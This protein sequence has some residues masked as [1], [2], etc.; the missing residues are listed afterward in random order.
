MLLKKGFERVT[1][2]SCG[3]WKGRSL[4]HILIIDTSLSG[5]ALATAQLT[6]NSYTID[7]QFICSQRRAAE[8]ELA[9]QT[10]VLLAK[11]ASLT[12]VIVS[13]GPGS[14]TGIR[15]G[16]AFAC[17]LA[18]STQRLLGISS[19][20]AIAAWLALERNTPC[21]LYHA[22][23]AESGVVAYASESAVKLA[24]INLPMPPST[25]DKT[26]VLIAGTW[27]RLATQLGERATHI[28]T[29]E[30][31]AY[32]LQALAWEA[33]R[34]ITVQAQEW[35]QPLYLKEPYVGSKT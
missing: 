14:F 31:L 2:K 16:I 20:R 22:I 13:I 35:P 17:G 24:N 9:T 27:P 10:K 29:D 1:P 25:S 11:T 26:Q 4:Q 8:R 28:D 30:L 5:V 19:L 3:D 18:G 15:I 34:M 33:Q 6:A 21:H 32:A 23:T 7:N 12:K